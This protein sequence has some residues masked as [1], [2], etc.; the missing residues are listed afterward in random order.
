MISYLVILASASPT[1]QAAAVQ[2]AQA[3]FQP[4]RATA[5]ALAQWDAQFD[6]GVTRASAGRKM[7][8]DQEIRKNRAK[9]AGKAELSQQLKTVAIPKMMSLI[10]AEY[11][12]NYSESEL[13]E[14]AAF[15]TSSA[16]VAFTVAMQDAIKNGTCRIVPPAEHSAAIGRYLSSATGRK[17]SARSAILRPALAKEMG[18]FM[19]QVQPKVDARMKAAMAAAS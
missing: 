1:A 11:I 5:D 4:E 10:E 8:A 9:A 2:I 15:W 16:G 7:T 3:T 12:Q 19:Q 18:L 14:A 17:E 6:A 13:R